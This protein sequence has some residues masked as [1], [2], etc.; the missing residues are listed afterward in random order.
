MVGKNSVSRNKYHGHYGRTAYT[1][2]TLTLLLIVLTCFELITPPP[3]AAFD[4]RCSRLQLTNANTQTPWNTQIPSLASV[5]NLRKW[6]KDF[7]IPAKTDS[8]KPTRTYALLL[9]TLSGDIHSN[10]GPV[11]FPCKVCKNLLQKII[12]QKLVTIVTFWQHIEC[13]EIT[14]K[15]YEELKHSSCVWIFLTCDQQNFF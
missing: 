10:P 7:H 2:F 4:N 15:E 5:E 8:I 3:S 12:E 14:P 11:R 6:N 9:L 13:I 1:Y